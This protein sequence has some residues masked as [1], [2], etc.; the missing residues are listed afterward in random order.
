MEAVAACPKCADGGAVLLIEVPNPAA[1]VFSP[2]PKGEPAIV[3]A[4]KCSKCG[5]ML[6]VRNMNSAHK[7]K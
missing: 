3:L 2:L 5:W 6:E 4:C 7:N 1:S